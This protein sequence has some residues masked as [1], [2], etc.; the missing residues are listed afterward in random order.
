MPGMADNYLN[1]IAQAG[2]DKID[3]IALL[4][5][6]NSV[7]EYQSVVWTDSGS[8]EDPAGTIRPD[9][10]ITFSV[11]AGTTVSGWRGYDVE[12]GDEYGGADFETPES[13][14][15]SGKFI[16]EADKT[17]IAHDVADDE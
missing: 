1:L 12:N 15:N 7:I 16:L 10:D 11:P 9:S 6:D 8:G 3:F 5:D 14:N 17:Y 2:A 13:Y 4:D